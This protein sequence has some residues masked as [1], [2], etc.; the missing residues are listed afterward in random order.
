[1]K[2]RGV[3]G[4]RRHAFE[5]EY[6]SECAREYRVADCASFRFALRRE[7]HS[8]GGTSFYSYYRKRPSAVHYQGRPSICRATISFATSMTHT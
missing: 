5:R 2:P 4:G 1:M 6:N 8:V 3:R 7:D